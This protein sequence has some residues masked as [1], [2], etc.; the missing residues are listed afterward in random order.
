LFFSFVS[1]A[2]VRGEGETIRPVYFLF[3]H[4]Q[5]HRTEPTHQTVITESLPDIEAITSGGGGPGGRRAK[6]PPV[7]AEGSEAASNI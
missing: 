6:A 5:L 3:F 7:I 1:L 4:H 2:A